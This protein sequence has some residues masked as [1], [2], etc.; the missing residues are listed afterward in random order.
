MPK[1]MN[2]KEILQSTAQILM[3]RTC[4]VCGKALDG[5]ERYICRKCLM[6][7]PRTMYEAVPL[8]NMAQ[9]FVGAVPVER[10]S[11]YFFYE[12]NAP[13]SQILQDIKYR[14]VPDM[15]RWLARRYAESTA[16]S[17]LWDGID[18]LIPVP[19]HVGKLAKRGY[20]QALYIALGISDAAQIP[21]YEAIDAVKGHATQT[22]KSAF[23]RRQNTKGLYA[24]IPE[25]DETLTGKHVM[26]IDDVITTGATLLSCAESL[27]HIPD[28]SISFFTLA[29][30][31]LA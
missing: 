15:G 9:R 7:M 23:E 31:R 29:A 6:D 25:A 27:C 17:G 21:V 30:A 3:P 2:I 4:P 1:A 14:N 12:R 13:Y 28:I 24:S 10:A 5:G 20:N 22:H 16:D 11:A 19:L 18:Y 8:N 26:I